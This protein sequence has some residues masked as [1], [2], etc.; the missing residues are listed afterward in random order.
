M[1]AAHHCSFALEWQHS[2][3]EAKQQTE[4]T[5]ETSQR[6]YIQRRSTYSPGL[7]TNVA[8]KTIGSDYG[9]LTEQ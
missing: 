9:I 2:A 1:L 3:E 4:A 5:R 7:G 8:C 6:Y